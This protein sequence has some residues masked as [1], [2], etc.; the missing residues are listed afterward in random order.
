MNMYDEVFAQ[1][2]E[3]SLNEIDNSIDHVCIA[4]T[5]AEGKYQVFISII[6]DDPDVSNLYVSDLC[7]NVYDA[8]MNLS[9][10]LDE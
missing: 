1:I 7:N 3:S 6:N 8:I 4:F 2:V 10:K 9:G 5:R